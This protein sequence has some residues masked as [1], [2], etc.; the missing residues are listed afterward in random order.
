MTIDRIG[1][2]DPIPPGKKPGRS[3]QVSQ[4]A[5]TDS[6]SLSSEALEKSEQLQARELIFAAADVRA[7]RIAE[8]KSKIN[9]PSYINETILKG[10]A[11]KIMEA[12]GL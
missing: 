11:D 6:I 9:D 2:I 1:S 12:F 5:K 3:G 7:E 10:T 4:N 8:M